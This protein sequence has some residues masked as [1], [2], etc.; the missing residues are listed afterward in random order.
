M[1]QVKNYKYNTFLKEMD[2]FIE[3]N[4]STMDAAQIA[5]MVEHQT[6]QAVV[7]AAKESIAEN[8]PHRSVCNRLNSRHGGCF[9][10]PI[11]ASRYCDYMRPI[12]QVFID[13]L[14]INV[15]KI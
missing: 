10:A 1:G 9:S 2:V 3:N 13:K 14:S 8:C 11:Y 5:V 7:R 4:V 12:M 6:F 15:D